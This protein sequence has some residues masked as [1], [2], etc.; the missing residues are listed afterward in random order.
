METIKKVGSFGIYLTIIVYGHMGLYNIGAKTYENFQLS[1]ILRPCY[2][3]HEFSKYP[4]HL[5]LS[6]KLF[7]KRECH[8]NSA[9][10]FY[11]KMNL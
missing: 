8:K 5:I 1:E 6:L 10:L 11:G 7:K 2:A 9:I 3:V 4:N